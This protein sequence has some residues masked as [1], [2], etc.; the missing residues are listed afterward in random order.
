VPFA[1]F[2]DRRIHYQLDGEPSAPLLVLSNSLG[3]DLHMWD[4][5][6]HSLAHKIQFLR[7]D[8][9][10]HGQSSVTLG[11]YSIEQLGQD[12]VNLLDYLGQDRVHFC[13]LSLGGLTGIWLASNHSDRFHSFVFC[14]TAAKIGQ[15]E[16]WNARI[17]A[18]RSCGMQAIVDSVMERWFSPQFRS[19]HPKAIAS[20]C[21]TLV[22]LPSDGYIGC[23][24]ALRDTDLRPQLSSIRARVL[25]IAGRHDA[26]TTPA[27][28]EYLQRNIPDAQ[29]VKLEAAHLSNIEDPPEFNSALCQFLA[30]ET[31][32]N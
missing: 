12:V 18:V 3:T 14:N 23:C 20:M 6:V 24:Q 17:D 8:T 7:Y 10:G 27:D 30:I 2:S 26:A 11:P 16:T 19:S 32:A 4:A 22:T 5:Q 25:V 15:A 1:Q 29:Y 13:G 21:N 9:R 31:E 28:G